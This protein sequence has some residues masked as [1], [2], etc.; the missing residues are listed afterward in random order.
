MLKHLP[1]DSL[2]VIQ[3]DLLYCQK[4]VVIPY[5]FDRR[6]SGGLKQA[7]GTLLIRVDRTDEDFIEREQK[8][9]NQL[10][11]KYVYRVPLKYIC[12]LGKINFP[13]KIDIEIRLTL[14]TDTKRLF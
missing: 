7:D 4:K 9:R 11:D 13:T 5:G 1:P 10:K 14:E 6:V 3:N 12:D 8:F 2:A